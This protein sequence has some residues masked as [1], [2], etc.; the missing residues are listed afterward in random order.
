MNKLLAFGCSWTQGV[1]PDHNSWAKE[2]AILNPEIVVEDFS[3][4][5]S[6]VKWSASQ[7]IKHQKKHTTTKATKT[8]F[9]ITH[10][11][12]VTFE[13]QD[14]DA[15][16]LREQVLDNYAKTGKKM[17]LF[18]LPL[19]EIYKERYNEIYTLEQITAAHDV[20]FD[21]FSADVE[22][23]EHGMYIN[24]VLP[25]VDFAFAHTIYGQNSYYKNYGVRLPSVEEHFGEKQ[26][27]N[28]CYDG[29][30]H[31]TAEGCREVAKWIKANL[32]K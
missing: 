6:S 20:V 31:F 4:G 27:N 22:F 12:R 26:F 8:V 30:K 9:Q 21:A 13:Y 5:G 19:K 18:T 11:G 28:W 15:D 2:F 32:T 3:L 1:P 14:I 29:G 7:L 17:S 23:I 24:W 10:P 25:Q 16:S